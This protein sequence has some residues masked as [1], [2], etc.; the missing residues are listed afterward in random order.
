MHKETSMAKNPEKANET[1]PPVGKD[2]FE[3]LK[4]GLALLLASKTAIVGL[5]LVMFWVSIALFAPYITNYGPID[6]DWKAPNQ[7]PPGAIPWAR[8]NWGGICGPGW[9]M[10][11]ASSW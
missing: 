3:K 1:S 4:D 6:Q 2:R 11:P 5:F 8:T 9:S 7:G 10:A